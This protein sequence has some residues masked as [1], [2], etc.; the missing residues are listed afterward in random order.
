MTLLKILGLL[1]LALVILVPLIER[2]GPRPDA[3]ATARM[4]RWVLPLLMLLAVL[5]LLIYWFG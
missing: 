1:L 4:S 2:F 5:Q 3:Q